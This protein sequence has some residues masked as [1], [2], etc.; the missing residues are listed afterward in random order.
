VLRN[1]VL[2]FSVQVISGLFYAFATRNWY[3]DALE[4]VHHCKGCKSHINLLFCILS[5]ICNDRFIV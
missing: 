4:Y 3:F 1:V 5:L 2:K